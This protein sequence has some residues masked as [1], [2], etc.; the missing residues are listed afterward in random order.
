MNWLRRSR[1]A[2]RRISR[3][4]P[5]TRP[6]PRPG[7]RSGIG[8]RC[9]STARGRGPGWNIRHE[10]AYQTRSAWPDSGNTNPHRPHRSRRNAHRSGLHP[11]RERGSACHRSG[12]RANPA[13]LSPPRERVPRHTDREAVRERVRRTG[14]HVL[15]VNGCRRRAW[16]TADGRPMKDVC[17]RPR[18]PPARRSGSSVSTHAF[19]LQHGARRLP[20]PLKTRLSAITGAL[21]V[22]LRIAASAAGR[23]TAIKLT[24]T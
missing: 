8:C 15:P 9:G 1:S 3:T 22:T 7:G 5:G 13:T 23:N 24:A 18:L 20:R 21:Q 11:H 4:G 14:P 12:S 6:R 17:C 19:L 16:G 2:P 10:D